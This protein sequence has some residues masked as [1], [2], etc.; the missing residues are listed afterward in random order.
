MFISIKINYIIA[1]SI[2]II[3]IY[4]EKYKNFFVDNYAINVNKKRLFQQYK[5]I[6]YVDYV[7]NFKILKYRVKYF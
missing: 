2:I 7:N 3:K 4:Y 1:R 6:Q 5:A